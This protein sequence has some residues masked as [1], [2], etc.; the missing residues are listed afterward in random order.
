MG[1]CTRQASVPGARL[2]GRPARILASRL[3]QLQSDVRTERLDS[4]K[5]GHILTENGGGDGGGRSG[6]GAP[7]GGLGR[8]HP[9]C[10]CPC[11]SACACGYI[12]V[13]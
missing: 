9:V 7:E 1:C 13:D 12:H 10:V 2:P 5:S 3:S 8:L 4:R 6:S 11:A